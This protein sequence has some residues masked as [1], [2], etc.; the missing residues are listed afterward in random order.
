MTFGAMNFDAS[1]ILIQIEYE[2]RKENIGE[3]TFLF[4]FGRIVKY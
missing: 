4:Y 1:V 3:D 2:I